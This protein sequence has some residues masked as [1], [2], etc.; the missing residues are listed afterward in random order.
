MELDKKKIVI[1]N[2]RIAKLINIIIGLILVKG[3]KVH[4]ISVYLVFNIKYDE[5]HRKRLVADSYRVDV[6]LLSIYSNSLSL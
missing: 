4:K 3:R 2:R 6:S 1:P 5:K